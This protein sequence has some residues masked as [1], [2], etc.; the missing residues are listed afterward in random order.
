MEK[1]LIEQRAREWAEKYG[2]VEYRLN[3]KYMIYNVSY[4]ATQFERHYTMQRH[5]NLERMRT[6]V[7]KRLKRYDPK[8]EVNR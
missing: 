3:G 6:V 4:P 5:V 1:E 8:G 2:I 7:N